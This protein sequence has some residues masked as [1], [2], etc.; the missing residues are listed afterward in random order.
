[1]EPI[2]QACGLQLQIEG[3]LLCVKAVG[4]LYTENFA[5]YQEQ[6]KPLQQQLGGAPW[7]LLLEFNDKLVVDY[8]L[9]LLIMKAITEGRALGRKATAIIIGSSVPQPEL[10]EGMLSK[11]YNR[12]NEC[13]AFFEDADVAKAWLLKQLSAEDA[14]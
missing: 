9:A 8:D 13:H 12:A 6:M 5:Q 3:P 1:M 7:G 2:E 4:S 10:V 11:V 14:G